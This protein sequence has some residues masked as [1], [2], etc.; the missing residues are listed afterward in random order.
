MTALL[1]R[2]VPIE[3]ILTMLGIIMLVVIMVIAIILIHEAIGVPIIEAEQGGEI[4]IAI[5]LDS[6]TMALPMVVLVF[7][8]QQGVNH[9]FPLVLIMVITFQFVKFATKRAHYC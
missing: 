4:N 7:L 8:V 5:I 6:L 1:L 3:A 2:M 9:M